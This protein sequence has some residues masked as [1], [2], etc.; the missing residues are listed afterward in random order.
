MPE[1]LGKSLSISGGQETQSDPCC[2]HTKILIRISLKGRQRQGEKHIACRM[3]CFSGQEPVGRAR[4]SARLNSR[5]K[6]RCAEMISFL[7]YSCSRLLRTKSRLWRLS[8]GE[9]ED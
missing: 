4:C 2:M 8:L 6:R 9:S 7:V 1:D 5:G 3:G